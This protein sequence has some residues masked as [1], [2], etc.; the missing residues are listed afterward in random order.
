MINAPSPTQS[1]STTVPGRLE[2][3]GASRSA[4]TLAFAWRTALRIKYVPEQLVDVVAVPLVFT[5][6][7]TYLLGG[8]LAGSPSSYLH[9]LLPGTLVMTLVL[10]TTF[11][12]TGLRSDLSS[13]VHDRFQS[14][15]VWRPAPLVGALVGD[16]GRYLLAS[17]IVFGLGLAMGFRPD[18]GVGG[19]LAALGLVLVF[20]HALSWVWIV[21]GISVRNV[22]AVNAIN[23]GVQLPLTM[24][25]NVFVDPATMPGWLRPIIENNPISFVVTATRGLMHGEAQLSEVLWVL[26]IAGALLVVF[27]PLSLYKYRTHRS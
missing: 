17:S 24:A 3:R 11:T 12:G 21:V 14:L 27:V 5:V 4:A 1:P 8:A 2:T 10:L 7:F 22:S 6:M 26:A 9:S 25:S 13:G 15:P 19:A 23:I 20:A 16:L 18:G